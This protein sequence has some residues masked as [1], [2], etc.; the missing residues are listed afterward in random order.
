MTQKRTQLSLFIAPPYSDT[1]ECIRRLFNP[2][3]YA[4]IPAHVTLCREDELI[5]IEKI[6][7]K[8]EELCLAPISIDFGDVIR[9]SDGEG[10]LIP[11]IGDC[12]PFQKL[13]E[14]ILQGM[15]EKPRRQDPHITLMHPR[16]ATCT[17]SIFDEIKGN[18][19]PGKI[20]FDKISLIE[21]VP[22]MR[23]ER[24][25]EFECSRANDS[26]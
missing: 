26:F 9:F 1:I 21:Q 11:A 15:I 20:V 14:N 10:V 3:Q 16:N 18:S 8:L 12:A 5:D 2:L 4:L 19:F 13:R 25:Q 24:I 17:D 7:R 22:G 23:W 6:F